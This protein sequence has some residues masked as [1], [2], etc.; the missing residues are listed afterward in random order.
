MELNGWLHQNGALEQGTN[1]TMK[2]IAQQL[3]I[4]EFPFI[5]ND[6]NGREIYIEQSNGFWWKREYNS[7]GNAIYYEDSD[8][9]WVKREFD[10]K[11]NRIYYEDSGGKIEDN[12]PKYTIDWIGYIEYNRPNP[13]E[14]KLVEVDGIKYKLVKA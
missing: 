9:F 8:G 6:K 4:K 11:G 1:I 7:I 12:R 14:G 10:T 3:N 2:T 5:I 13:C